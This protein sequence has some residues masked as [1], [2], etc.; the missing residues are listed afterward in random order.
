MPEVAITILGLGRV[1]TSIG[2]ALKA[3]SQRPGAKHQFK[4]TGYSGRNDHIKAAQKMGAVDQAASHIYDAVRGRDIVV[5]AMPYAEVE[6]AYSAMKGELRPGVVVLDFSPLKVNP[7][8]W[9]AKHLSKDAHVVGITPLLN[10]ALL[11]DPLDTPEKASAELF[12]D[13][14]ALLMPSVTCIPEAIELGEDFVAILGS[15]KQYIDP[16]EHDSVLAATDVLPTL[17]GL[18]YYLSLSTSTGWGDLQRV[19]NPAFGAMTRALFDTHP[20]DLTALLRD[21]RDD[22][23]R[24]L[25]NVIIMLRD[26]RAALVKDE[27]STIEAATTGAAESYEGWYNRRFHWKFDSPDKKMPESPGM[28]S[29]F[30]GNSLANRLRGKKDE[31]GQS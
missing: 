5:M 31:D 3:Y 17:L 9:A 30:L 16:A 21:S 26:L 28:M 24:A 13:G 1:G 12:K 7:L 22:L 2:L 25:D 15:R 19:T 14:T 4:V 10:P 8:K 6:A 27:R 20:D 29:M 18:S 11:F 23:V